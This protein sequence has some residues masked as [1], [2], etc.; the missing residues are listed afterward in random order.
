MGYIKFPSG[1]TGVDYQT[2]NC[3]NI[4]SVSILAGKFLCKYA[5]PAAADKV[6]SAV[7]GFTS[8]NTE[9]EAKRLEKAIL[10][11]NQNPGSCELFESDTDG[12]TINGDIVILA[13]QD[14]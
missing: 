6:L 12:A 10:R 4:Y 3:S 1:Y 7:I 11:A 14:S 8:T 2:W 9:A 5:T 13:N